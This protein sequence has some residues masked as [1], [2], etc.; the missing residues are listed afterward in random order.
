[1]IRLDDNL[2]S[3]SYKTSYQIFVYVFQEKLSV[4]LAPPI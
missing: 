3:I 1:M 4:W 2:F